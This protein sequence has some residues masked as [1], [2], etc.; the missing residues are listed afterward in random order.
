MQSG[1]EARGCTAALFIRTGR[2]R[3]RAP[4]RHG[5]LDQAT[6]VAPH[7]F[8]QA[9]PVPLPLRRLAFARSSLCSEPPGSGTDT[10]SPT[11]SRPTASPPRG[12]HAGASPS[13]LTHLISIT[14]S[15]VAHSRTMSCALLADVLDAV[16]G[17]SSP[18][19]RHRFCSGPAVTLAPNP[20][21]SPSSPAPL[22]RDRRE[23]IRCRTIG[24]RRAAN[25]TAGRSG[26]VGLQ[27]LE[28]CP[29]R[30]LYVHWRPQQI[31]R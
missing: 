23:R 15:A 10:A 6:R 5:A 18:S 22:G 14:S 11:R 31:G 3:A 16:L 30:P 4:R 8:G 9:G 1:R 29:D 20:R 27:L 17:R 2:S 13:L 25:A 7:S 19:E 21:S 24:R 28:D 26:I 12:W